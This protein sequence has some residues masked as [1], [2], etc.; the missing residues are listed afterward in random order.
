MSVASRN[1]QAHLTTAEG[2]LT[3]CRRVPLTLRLYVST[4]SLKKF[5]GRWLHGPRQKV[6]HSPSK[7]RFTPRL[8]GGD[9]MVARNAG[10][11]K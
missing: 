3:Q 7:E 8:I 9:E 11:R 5:H 2:Q 1:D 10:E 4:A 6:D